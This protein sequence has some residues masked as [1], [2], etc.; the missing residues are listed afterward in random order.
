MTLVLPDVKAVAR[1]SGN[2]TPKPS[3]NAAFLIQEDC[4]QA[5]LLAS[6]PFLRGVREE[7]QGFG[8]VGSECPGFALDH[9]VLQLA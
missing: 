6:C 9:V 7:V 5:H 2:K 4:T 3:Q 1:W 8:S